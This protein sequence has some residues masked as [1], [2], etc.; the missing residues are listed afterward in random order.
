MTLPRRSHDTPKTLLRRSQDTPKPVQVVHK[1]TKHKS[2]PPSPV[3]P[4][5]MREARPPKP[6]AEKRFRLGPRGMIYGPPATLASPR[7]R[8]GPQR[9]ERE[10][11]RVARSDEAS[12]RV[13]VMQTSGHGKY[14]ALLN[15]TRIAN[16][17]WA[18]K[19]GYDYLSVKGLYEGAAK[20]LLPKWSKGS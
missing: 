15:T 14:E 16:E 11:V 5:T 13:L 12:V 8:E 20:W 17:R 19:H 6:S 4:P 9:I 18:A 10:W 3:K 7:S 1:H 2:R